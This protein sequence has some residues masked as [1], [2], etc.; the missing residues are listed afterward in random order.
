MR[1]SRTITIT[2]CHRCHAEERREGTD[3]DDVPATWGTVCRDRNE[4][5]IAL[6]PVCDRT[7][8]TFLVG[9]PVAGEPEPEPEAVPVPEPKRGRPPG[10]KN[11]PKVEP[12]AEVV[13]VQAED[14]SALLSR[15][16]ELRA[17]LRDKGH[18]EAVIAILEN[19]PPI[20]IADW[21]LPADELRDLIGRLEVVTIPF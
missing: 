4:I 6:C 7:L 14:T 17:D 19:T 12:V 8:T 1:I 11:K 20:P 2:E 10:A 16:I 9:G 13:P 15:I 3:L 18:G 21:K 5:E